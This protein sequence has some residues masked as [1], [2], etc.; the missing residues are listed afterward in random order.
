M[1]KILRGVCMMAVVALA[2]T[3]CKKNN[4]QNEGI[5]FSGVTEAFEVTP[6]ED[7]AYIGTNSNQSFFEINDQIMVYN[8]DEEATK[9]NYGI[10]WTKTGGHIVDWFYSSGTVINHRDASTTTLFAFYPAEIVNNA[11]L[12]EGDNEAMF[13]IVDHQTYRKLNGQVVVP[14]GTLAMAAKDEIAQDVEEEQFKFKN[15]MGVL[16]LNLKSSTG[17]TVKSIVYEDNM[18]YVTGRVHLKINQV[19]PDEMTWL[20]NNYNPSNTTYMNRL[21][22]YIDATNYF[23]DDA[24]VSLKGKTMTLDCGDGVKLNSTA[25]PFLIT[26]RPL[27]GYAGFK[28]TINFTDDS[29]YVIT[30]TNNNMIKPNDIRD[31]P[32]IN[33][34]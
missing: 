17:K 28:V 26:L 25:Q 6:C 14:K 4:E 7:R 1:K 21:Q 33:V 15:I 16:K 2:F 3:S 27:A 13:E 23:V 31:M 10:Y 18:F 34:G 20:I 29:S 12:W 24:H 11:R 19:D 9:T 8:L 22:D 5:R 32:A 30:T